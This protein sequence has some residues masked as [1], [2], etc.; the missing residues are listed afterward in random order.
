MNAVYIG[1]C[2]WARMLCHEVR[3]SKC[4]VFEKNQGV[5]NFN[6]K[7]KFKIIFFLF[8]EVFQP[9]RMVNSQPLNF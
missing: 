8:L 7:I 4:A 2:H 5:V 3:Y 9:L 6:L 1:I